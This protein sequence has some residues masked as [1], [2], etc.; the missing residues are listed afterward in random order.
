MAVHI[1]A[2]IGYGHIVRHLVNG[3]VAAA[4]PPD[5]RRAKVFVAPMAEEY[6]SRTVP[7]V[8]RRSGSNVSVRISG[9]W[10]WADASLCSH[11]TLLHDPWACSFLPFTNC[12]DRFL[13]AH[14]EHQHP[15]FYWST[16]LAYLEANASQGGP[17][18]TQGLRDQ[19]NEAPWL[20]QEQW[21]LS[22]VHAFLQ[23]PNHMLR[24]EMR[25]CFRNIVNAK[26]LNDV[27]LIDIRNGHSHSKGRSSESG[28]SGFL[29][30]GRP[31]LAMH[32]RHNDASIDAR[33]DRPIDRSLFAHVN[34]SLPFLAE[35]DI[36]DIF[37]ATDNATIVET[38]AT[39]Y[40]QYNW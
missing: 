32:I 9:G 35:N 34:A 33:G 3:F 31:C 37:V 15:H 40:P 1:M 25:H 20:T 4:M 24:A 6:I 26:Q 22:R 17:A 38:V 12:S 2:N 19:L 36:T 30:N 39:L 5:P 7:A 21:A 8:D 18:I 23:R 16:P 27:S 10:A 13:S 29:A 14:I 28:H 11:E